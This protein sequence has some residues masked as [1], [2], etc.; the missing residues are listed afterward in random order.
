M[1]EPR[2]NPYTGRTENRPPPVEKKG[3]Q[4]PEAG[5]ASRFPGGPVALYDFTQPQ[6]GPVQPPPVAEGTVTPGRA[7]VDRNELELAAEREYQGAGM[8]GAASAPVGSLG[9]YK[10]RTLSLPEE[11]EQASKQASEAIQAELTAGREY[12]KKVTPLQEDE[13]KRVQQRMAAEEGRMG[14]LVD[15][16]KQQQTLT[17]EMGKRV[18]SFRVDPNRI[19]G[20]G[21]ERAATTFGLGIASALSNIGEAMQGKAATNQ[22]LSLVQN[23]IAQDIGLQENDYRRMLQ[24]YEVKRNGLMDSI[25]QVGDERLGA[26]ALAKQQGLFYADQLGKIAKQVGLTDAQAAR[27][28]LEAQARI[29]QGLGEQKGRVEQFNVAAQNQQA[30]FNASLEAQR[31]QLEEQR[32]ISQMSTYAL[33]EKD[34]ERIKTQLD[35]ANEKQLVQRS[36]GLREMKSMLQANPNVAESTKGL[37][38]SFVNSVAG[39]SQPGV[40]QS[41]L[42]QLAVENLSPQDQQFVRAYQRYIGGRLTALGGKAITANEK[43]LFNLANYTSP[44]QFGALLD[45]ESNGLRDDAL[46]IWKTSGLRGDASL[47]LSR[48]LRGLY[49]GLVTEPTEKPPEAK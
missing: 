24:G 9:G 36:A 48:D 42:A 32:R 5:T 23:R 4:G 8:M 26:E 39:E 21:G 38:Q 35:K 47:I 13:S 34:Q 41:K 22:I 49:Q 43:A 18:E 37:I 17:E 33:G 2:I 14:R 40:I 10:A 31:R 16:G 19:F 11:I 3:F 20:Q 29:L 28:L 1:A 45:E 30:Q 7:P 12:A 27:P 15:L 25:R 6:A 44:K 46:S